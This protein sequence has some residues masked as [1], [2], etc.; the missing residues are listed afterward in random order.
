YSKGLYVLKNTKAPAMLIECCF[1]DDKDDVQLYD[2]QKMAEAIVYGITGQQIH[3]EETESDADREAVE[4]GE[5]TTVGD[6]RRLKK[7]QLGAYYITSNAEAVLERAK[8]AGF[9]DAIIVNA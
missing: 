7:V 4:S 6:N 1:V 2:C 5:E 3:I 8:A 9:N